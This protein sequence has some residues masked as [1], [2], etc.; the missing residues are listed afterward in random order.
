MP[1][2]PVVSI[3]PGDNKKKPGNKNDLVKVLRKLGFLKPRK[4]RTNKHTKKSK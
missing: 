2:L 3:K 1:L 4:K